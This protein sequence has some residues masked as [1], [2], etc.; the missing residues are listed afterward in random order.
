MGCCESRDKTPGVKVRPFRGFLANQE[1]CDK[2]ISPAYD[3]LDTNE[4]RQMAE[5]N[6][7]SFLHVNKPEIDLD[8]ETDPY[9]DEVYQQGRQNLLQFISDGYLQQDDEETMYIYRQ[10]MNGHVQQGIVALAS[11][12][13]YES[14]KIKRHELTLPKKENDR[15]KLTE[16]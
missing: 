11:I 9:A 16:I 6:P 12:Q 7:M 4:A 14:N 1:H 13:D 3:V 10:V 8:P 2:V 15:T 5:G